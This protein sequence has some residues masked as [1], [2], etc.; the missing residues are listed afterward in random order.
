ML[1]RHTFAVLLAA[2]L[3][4]SL[5]SPATAAEDAPAF[6]DAL[7]KAKHFELSLE[8]I[9]SL[10]KDPRTSQETLERL[11][12][13][14]AITLLE[15]A[16]RLTSQQARAAAVDSARGDLESSIASG[17]PKLAAEAS[18]KLAAALRAGALR[19]MKT[20]ERLTGAKKKNAAASARRAIVDSRAFFTKAEELFEK[21]LK[22]LK[23]A[24]PAS[25]E[26]QERVILR[27]QLAQA[28]LQKSQALMDRARTYPPKSTDFKKHMQQAADELAELKDTYH[29]KQSIIVSFWAEYYE[30]RCRLELGDL[31]VAEGCFELLTTLPAE[32]TTLRRLITLGHTYRTVC[33]AMQDK[34]DFALR[35]A[36]K[37]LKRLTRQEQN[38]RDVLALKYQVAE[39]LQA[40]AKS[41]KKKDKAEELLD[42]AKGYYAEVSRGAGEFQA[43][44]R[45]KLVEMNKISGGGDLAITT[46]DE[47]YQV[48]MDALMA[49]SFAQAGADQTQ[50]KAESLAAFQ[51]AAKLATTDTPIH[52][53]NG[54]RSKL[55]YLYMDQEDH[56][57]AAA[58]GEF[59]AT[60][61]PND[62]SA[63]QA[64][65]IA[66]NSL[67]QL[68]LQAIESGNGDTR[69]ESGELVRLSKFVTR[70]FAGKPL[71]DSAFGVLLSTAIREN[72][73]DEARRVLEE[74]APERRG[75]LELKLA[76]A[77]WEQAARNGD[78]N[79]KSQAAQAL[80]TAVGKMRATGPVNA[81]L[82]TGALYLA[83]SRLGEGD[84]AGALKLLEDKK[85][86]PL[87]LVKN[88][89]AA[90]NRPGYAA[91]AYRT[92]LQALLTVAPP[93][94]VDAMAMMDKLEQEVTDQTALKRIY[95][96]LGVQ[97]QRQVESLSAAGNKA[98]AQ[99]VSQAFAEFISRFGDAGPDA[100]WVMQQWMAQ[101]YLKLGEGLSGPGADK[102]QRSA[103]FT[104]ARDGFQA[105]LDLAAKDPSAP[106]SPNSVLAVRMQLGNA[107]RALREYGPAI[108][109]FAKLLAE[110][111]MM[112]DVQ[113]SAAYTFQEWGQN[114][115]PTYFDNAVRGDRS[116]LK[117]GKN[118]IWGWARLAGIAGRAARSQPKYRD[119]FFESWLNVATCRYQAGKQATGGQQKKMFAS[120]RK[121]IKSLA[122]QY[123]D[124]GGKSR[125]ADFHK[126]MQNIQKSEGAK[127]IG[128]AEFDS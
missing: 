32:D 2:A 102:Q 61:Y 125:R 16:Q 55:A 91:E 30:G 26:A 98:D 76:S 88:K 45:M 35:E 121:T 128:L 21:A 84:A 18:F 33:L 106:P 62:P 69:F 92:A 9:D 71:A 46:F 124:L 39:L 90:V 93:R 44:A 100:D 86:G 36:N 22:P 113:K 115:D 38:D 97:L 4:S 49:A 107:L 111:E 114:E 53:V 95:F 63:E 104:R 74:V 43:D 122:R 8:F 5:A 79:V 75:P 123:S 73:L 41:E 12:Y 17:E 27:Y 89:S 28:R 126:L 31:R 108:D 105:L 101:T 118:L 47:A 42:M 127:P 94:T 117:T 48:G 51:Q 23:S 24:R 14:R 58:L 52:K 13:E 116:S 3:L 87:S 110:R 54:V 119:L 65:K 50:G 103:Y 77:N 60:K 29:T 15:Q 64:S 1:V 37:W 68:Y 96:A 7:R 40:A 10:K 112:L 120:A 57:R 34:S 20:S 78:D 82:A 67:N 99:W 83:Q 6:L 72:R 66:L 56:L 85:I 11:D 109:M 25:A 70:R 81:S 19:E 80:D 59:I